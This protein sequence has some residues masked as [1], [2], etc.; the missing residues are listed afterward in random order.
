MASFQESLNNFGQR[1]TENVSNLNNLNV[2][3]GVAPADVNVNMMDGGILNSINQFVR[4]E[5]LSSV[6][7]EIGNYRV[8][9]GGRLSR[10]STSLS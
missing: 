1:L 6:A 9:E 10:S 7:Q 4:N 2:E 8:G 3:V 5:M